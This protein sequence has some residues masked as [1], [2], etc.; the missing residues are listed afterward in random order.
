MI[1][2]ISLALDTKNWL[3]KN[4]ETIEEAKNRA[5][6][7]FA[8]ASIEFR[9]APFEER[10]NPY[11]YVLNNK[12]QLCEPKTDKRPSLSWTKESDYLENHAFE[13]MEFWATQKFSKNLAW[14][15]PPDEKHGYTEARLEV[16]EIEKNENKTRVTCRAFCLPYSEGECLSLAREIAKTSDH[17]VADI[18]SGDALRKHPVYFNP[19]DNLTWYAYLENKIKKPEIWKKVETGDDYKNKEEALELSGAVV[20]SHFGLIIAAK[21]AYERVII[22]AAMEKAMSFSGIIFQ[23]N[24]SCGISNQGALEIFKRNPGIF[25][26]IFTKATMSFQERSFSCPKCHKAIPSGLGITVCPHCGAKKEDYG[27]CA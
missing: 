7:D 9:E 17:N 20:D 27:K 3:P 15:S 23:T 14:F 13:L 12:G 2:E 11:S 4:G 26:S 10:I 18:N 24:G 1:K 21:D 5:V 25:N 6:R 16:S 8:A 19:P 22:G